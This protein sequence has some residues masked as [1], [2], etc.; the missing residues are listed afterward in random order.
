MTELILKDEVYRI[1]GAAMEVYYSLGRG[2]L[3]PVY[4]Q[5]M[6]I[7]LGRRS[8]PFEPQKPLAIYYKGQCLE[9]AYKPDFICF[10]L[11]VVEIKALD[12]LTT[13]EQAQLLN[14]MRATELRVGVLINFCSTPKL[15]WKRYVL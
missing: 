5:A 15:E 13:L 1:I 6:E 14:Y 12:R 8:I 9:K 2:F 4:Q 10:G 3:E 11:V 7:E